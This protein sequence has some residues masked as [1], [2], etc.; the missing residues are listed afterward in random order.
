MEYSV[1]KLERSRVEI[2]VSVEKNS[3]T[4]AVLRAYKKTKGHYRIEGF[5]PRKAPFNVI[6]KMCK[7]SFP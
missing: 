7:G 5:R 1:Q 3:G 2:A 4:I 6:V